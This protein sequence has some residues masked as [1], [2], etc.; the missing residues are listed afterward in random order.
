MAPLQGIRVLE[1]SLGLSAVGAGQAVSIP[2]SLLRD[3]GAEVLR[4]QSARAS[5]LDEGVE[6][7]RVWNLGK[8]ILDVDDGD[9]E[10]AAETII[11]RARDCDVL[12]LAGREQLIEQAGLQ[13]R[14]L[15][16]VNP[17]LI[18]VRV[19]PSRN[20]LGAL[21]DLELLVQA[22]AG[23]PTQIPAHRPGPAFGDLSAGSAGAGFSAAVGALAGLYS[24]ESTGRGG[25]AETSQ[26]ATR[27]SAS[28]HRPGRPSRRRASSG[29]RS[30]PGLRRKAAVRRARGD[31]SF[32]PAV[33]ASLDTC[34]VPL[35]ER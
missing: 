15:A 24:R 5:T 2:G 18:V 31:R 12:F 22:R 25:W 19:R 11:A 27:R 7:A 13:Y 10:R 35:G 34:A 28:S 8:E 29:D 30:R 16:A 33:R 32:Q 23:V 20:S 6:F 26:S 4:V 17:R 14:T 9:P 21:P 3:F 1:V